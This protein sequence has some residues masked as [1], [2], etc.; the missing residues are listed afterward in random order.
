MQ[1]SPMNLVLRLVGLSLLLSLSATSAQ[2]TDDHPADYL[3]QNEQEV[4]EL[5]QETGLKRIVIPPTAK[6][7]REL[8]GEVEAWFDRVALPPVLKK[9]AEQ[10]YGERA[11]A[12]VQQARVLVSSDDYPVD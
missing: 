9:L 2:S 7:W 10:P 3:P 11:I 5:M 6:R 4:A 12:F 8:D 1:H